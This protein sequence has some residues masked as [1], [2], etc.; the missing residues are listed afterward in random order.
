MSV[1]A[2]QIR[3]NDQPLPSARELGAEVVKRAP[4]VVEW[5]LHARW[6]RRHPG[7]PV[8]VVVP[9]GLGRVAIRGY[10]CAQRHRH[11]QGRRNEKC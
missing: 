2:V 7:S 5:R 3:K 4:H 9:L 11:D 8:M 1:A 10:D 6:H